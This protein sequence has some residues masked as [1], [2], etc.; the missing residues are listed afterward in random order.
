MGRDAGGSVSMCE[1]WGEVEVGDGWGDSSM[2]PELIRLTIADGSGV[3]WRLS[4]L[5]R[6]ESARNILPPVLLCRACLG[7]PLAVAAFFS[8]F[9]NMSTLNLS[10]FPFSFLAESRLLASLPPSPKKAAITAS[11]FACFSAEACFPVFSGVSFCS[12]KKAEITES[13]CICPRIISLALFSRLAAIPMRHGKQHL[14]G[15][16]LL[17]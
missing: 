3:F 11:V 1:P 6:G 5:G 4:T 17:P 12:A 8:F 13:A 10:F 14:G 15:A 2:E 9:L 16:Y 7:L